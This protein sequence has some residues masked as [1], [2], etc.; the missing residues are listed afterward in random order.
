MFHLLPLLKGWDYKFHKV[1]RTVKRGESVK[2][3]IAEIGWLLQV[4]L[5]T[6]DCYGT[7]K[8]TWQGAELQ[9]TEAVWSPENA[10]LLGAWA[11]DPSG[12]V[13]RY[14]RP[15]PFSSAGLY[16][17][18]AY[19]GWAEGSLLPYVP[20]VTMEVALPLESTQESAE[21]QLVLAVIVITDVKAFIAS[22]RRVLDAKADLEIDPALLTIGPAEFKEEKK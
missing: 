2:L 14:F 1:I 9:P 22:L 19:T 17:L 10:R 11:Q 7:A 3:D 16:V 18:S 5:V 8:I 15:N 6:T 21:M 20:T 4:S 13:Q 12:W